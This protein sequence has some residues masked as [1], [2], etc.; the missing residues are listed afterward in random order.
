MAKPTT[1]LRFELDGRVTTEFFE[2]YASPPTNTCEDLDSLV[3][4]RSQVTVASVTYYGFGNSTRQPIYELTSFVM[5]YE[6][7]VFDGSNDDLPVWSFGSPDANAPVSTFVANNGKTVAICFRPQA[8]TSNDANKYKN[9]PLWGDASAFMAITTRVSAGTYYITAY[10]WDGSADYAELA[11]PDGVDKS[12]LVILRHDTTTLYIDLYQE[13]GTHTSASTA[14]GSTTTM[15]GQMTF[16]NLSSTSVA[17]YKGRQNG[18]LIYNQALTS[19]T[20]DDLVAYMQSRFM[21]A[22]AGS[23]PVFSH[24]YRQMAAAG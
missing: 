20:Y 4:A 16:G 7:W 8:H 22:I 1:G 24:H 3:V 19:T 17:A 6:D 14:S 15:T 2:A 23:V 21:P 5:A 9:P 13:D 11:L 18:V 10:N 12:Y